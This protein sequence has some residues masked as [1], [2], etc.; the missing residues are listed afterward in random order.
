MKNVYRGYCPLRHEGCTAECEWFIPRGY[1]KG[2]AVYHLALY[3]LELR[4]RQEE[5]DAQSTAAESEKEP[6]VEGHTR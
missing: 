6:R 1:M 5:T 3:F 4:D 2:C